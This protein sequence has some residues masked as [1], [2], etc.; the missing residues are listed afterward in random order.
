MK[1]QAE[2]PDDDEEKDDEEEMDEGEDGVDEGDRVDAEMD[3]QCGQGE[4][5]KTPPRSDEP[6]A[7]EVRALV[8]K[9]FARLLDSA[10]GI[11]GNSE[12]TTSLS[13]TAKSMAVEDV[14]TPGEDELSNV[15]VVMPRGWERDMEL[16]G[17]CVARTEGL[18]V[19]PQQHDTC[20]AGEWQHNFADLN[21]EEHHKRF[22]AGR[23][24]GEVDRNCFVGRVLAEVARQIIGN[25][26]WA[27]TTVQPDVIRSSKGGMSAL[28]T[29]PGADLQSPHDDNTELSIIA[30]FTAEYPV[31]IYPGS[32]VLE[33]TQE[34]L[35]VGDANEVLM[36]R[37]GVFHFGQAYPGCAWQVIPSRASQLGPNVRRG[38]HV[39]VDRSLD[40]PQYNLTDTAVD[41]AA[42]RRSARVAE[43][44]LP[45]DLPGVT[46]SG[47]F[48]GSCAFRGK[49]VAVV[50]S[51]LTNPFVE[52]A[53]VETGAL[54]TVPVEELQPPTKTGHYLKG[55]FVNK[56]YGPKTGLFKTGVKMC[57]FAG[58]VMQYADRTSGLVCTGMP[59]LLKE[60]YENL[61]TA[62]G[63]MLRMGYVLR[64]NSSHLQGLVFLQKDAGD[65][66]WDFQKIALTEADLE[67]E[68][69][70]LLAFQYVFAEALPVVVQWT[71]EA[72]SRSFFSP[73][74]FSWSASYTS[75]TRC[76]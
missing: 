47:L 44:V 50:Q 62:H 70:S 56:L 49:D 66:G 11:C 60:D 24:I 17:F 27:C 40:V 23:W 65:K 31:G 32:H 37:R 29:L 54:K 18:E 33:D 55:Q 67:K 20:V 72:A 4:P 68:R 75:H 41:Y 69:R 36:F 43:D 10:G 30:C 9:V 8:K 21:A 35:F 71:Q 39:Y 15:R 28:L 74:L 1:Q 57:V 58:A 59:L 64:T 38:G 42:R 76:V 16:Q 2:P 73:V 5:W 26:G 45:A 63:R 34:S 48:L 52:I 13:E 6:I 53:C 61:P 51:P 46:Y 19:S 12:S 14:S 7:A 3:I 22:E 25:P